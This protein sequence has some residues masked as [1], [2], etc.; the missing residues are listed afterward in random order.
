MRTID[1]LPA[2]LLSYGIYKLAPKIE[3]AFQFTDTAWYFAAFLRHSWFYFKFTTMIRT[4]SNTPIQWDEQCLPD[5]AAVQ[6]LFSHIDG[7]F[8]SYFI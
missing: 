2:R 8:V 5:I 3:V 1:H 4:A 6:R 7:L